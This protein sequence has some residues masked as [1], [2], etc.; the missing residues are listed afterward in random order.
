[1]QLSRNVEV[2]AKWSGVLFVALISGVVGA[3]L[4]SHFGTSAYT[5]SYADFVSILL[6]CLGV[7]LTVVTL[8]VGLLAVLGWT[9]IEARLR[10]HSIEYIGS[11]LQEG[12]PLGE[13]VRKAVRDAVYEGV[14]PA[15]PE[16]D[17]FEDE[18]Q[19]ERGEQ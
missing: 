2:A 16:D 3:A 19:G 9:S 17:P 18:G 7:M 5:L 15:D 1:M 12:K 4:T 13:L 11:E 10:D 8:F 14:S 6:T